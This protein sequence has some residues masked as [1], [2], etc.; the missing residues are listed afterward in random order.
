MNQ[1]SAPLDQYDQLSV[2]AIT[3]RIRTL[4]SAGLDEVR[5]YEQEHAN[6]PAV[7][8]AVDRRAQQL[9]DGAEP[10]QGPARGYPGSSGPDAP[11]DQGMATDA[12]P[13]N[14]PSQGDP[15]NPSQPR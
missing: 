6:R 8:M 5:S 2:A 1:Q 10:V 7:L 13:N 3:E 15:T 4:D 12:P 9:A 11:R 14:P